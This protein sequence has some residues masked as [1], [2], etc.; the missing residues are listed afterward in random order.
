MARR[1]ARDVERVADELAAAARDAG[2]Q[3]LQG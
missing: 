2:T 3:P 1:N